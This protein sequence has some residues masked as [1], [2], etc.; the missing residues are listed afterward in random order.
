[1]GEQFLVGFE[2]S[3]YQIV[4]IVTRQN[5]FSNWMCFLLFSQSG[6]VACEDHET[7][8][9]EVDQEEKNYTLIDETCYNLEDDNTDSEITDVQI[10]A[11]ANPWEW[12]IECIKNEDCPDPWKCRKNSCYPSSLL[13]KHSSSGNKR[14]SQVQGWL[15]QL[16]FG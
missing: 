4:M 11:G 3:H 16:Q 8:F 13:Q 2:I 7:R 14:S 15:D 12:Q 10:F 5:L 6:K 9:N 1:M